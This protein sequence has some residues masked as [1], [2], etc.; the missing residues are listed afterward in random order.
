MLYGIVFISFTLIVKLNIFGIKRV[1][2]ES[3]I[4]RLRKE[5]LNQ[6]TAKS[7]A[8]ELPWE[9]E[10]KNSMTRDAGNIS[11]VYVVK[12]IASNRKNNNSIARFV[13]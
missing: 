9:L 10:T 8:R 5:L 12:I 11:Y 7:A 2:I 1:Q 6:R 13:E 3:K 4:P